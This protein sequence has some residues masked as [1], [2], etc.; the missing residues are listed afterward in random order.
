M[1]LFQNTF[2]RMLRTRSVTAKRVLSSL[3]WLMFAMFLPLAV[4]KAEDPKPKSDSATIEKVAL[5]GAT[6]MKRLQWDK[7]VGLTHP[8]ALQ[9]FREQFLPLVQ[10][11]AETGT[12]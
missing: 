6:A 1:K 10:L 11:G 7:V 12:H 3:G 4:C 5:E 9:H 2:L 8:E